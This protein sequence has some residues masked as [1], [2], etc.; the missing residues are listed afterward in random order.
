MS[1][2]ASAAILSWTPPLPGGH[3]RI[4]VLTLNRPEVANSFNEEIIRDLTQQLGTVAATKDCRALVLRGAGKHFSA[5]AD[6]AWMKASAQLSLEGNAK[7]A[8]TLIHLFEALCH[9]PVPTI[10][11][12]TGSAFGGAV[13]LAACCDVALAAD[14]ARFCLS[15]IRLGLLPAVILPYLA[16]KMLPGQLRRHALTGRLFN[17][18]EA[19]AFGLVQRVAP[20]AGLQDA[21][22]EE[23]NG[24]LAGS[25][26]AQAALKEL[27]HRVVSD[28]FKQ[29]PHTAEAIATQRVSPSGQA[30]LASFFDK[31]PTPWSAELAPGWHL[32]DAEPK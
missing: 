13:G 19:L 9:L 28:S 8:K 20:E 17:A 14:N 12:V 10:A 7:D 16:R 2:R 6:L 29:G 32:D 21:L 22:R 1:T 30:G 18:Q 24:I 23:L 5:G 31:R 3:G 11:L 26:E 15:E 27:L 25:P 4:A